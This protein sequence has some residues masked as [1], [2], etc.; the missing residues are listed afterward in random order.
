M[1]TPYETKN[2]VTVVFSSLY[3]HVTGFVV[4]TKALLK[5]LFYYILCWWITQWN[6]RDYVYC[7][8]YSNHSTAAETG[9]SIF[10]DHRPWILVNGDSPS[11]LSYWSVLVWSSLILILIRGYQKV[12][13]AKEGSNGGFFWTSFDHIEWI[14][15]LS[16]CRLPRSCGDGGWLTLSFTQFWLFCVFN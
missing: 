14:L 16:A 2:A 12:S 7:C 8:F 4:V 11:E 13:A 3:V 15:M 6:R 10:E 5:N 1:S 9:S